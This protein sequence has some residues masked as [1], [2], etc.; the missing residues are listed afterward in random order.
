MW[1]FYLKETTTNM[2]NHNF[3]QNDNS[4]I[5]TCI[6]DADNLNLVY[7]LKIKLLLHNFHTHAKKFA[8]KFDPNLVNITKI[9]KFW[10]KLW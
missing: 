10:P 5:C 4:N 1:M 7:Q 8:K 2:Q 3:H 9:L 6:S